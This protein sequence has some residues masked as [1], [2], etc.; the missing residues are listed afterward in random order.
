MV[1]APKT[2]SELRSVLRSLHAARVG[3]TERRIPRS[4][5]AAQPPTRAV[6]P[7]QSLRRRAH[8]AGV[9]VGSEV[10]VDWMLCGWRAVP[11]RAQGRPAVS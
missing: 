8:R 2:A 10:R 6:M 7:Y 4:G 1:P 11:A 5:A 3:S 9:W